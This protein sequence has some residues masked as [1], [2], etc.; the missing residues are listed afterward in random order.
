M[1][2]QINAMR[3][4]IA[5][6]LACCM[7]LPCCRRSSRTVHEVGAETIQ[8]EESRGTVRVFSLAASGVKS[9]LCDTG[10]GQRFGWNVQRISPDHIRL[11]TGDVGA[12]DIFNDGS[13]CIVLPVGTF[14]SPSKSRA[15]K[16]FGD[17]ANV[18]AQLGDT[19]PPFTDVWISDELTIASVKPDD[20][21]VVWLSDS[22]AEVRDVSGKVIGKLRAK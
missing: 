11:T 5:V 14:L 4:T 20:L 18:L 6:A 3:F 16:L 12:F 21:T 8:I 9:E 7:V 1:A 13:G 22:L 10:A 2:F 15:V 17:G 19:S